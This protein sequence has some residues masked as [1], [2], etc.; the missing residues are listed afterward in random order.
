VV[1]SPAPKVARDSRPEFQH[2]SADSL[3]SD[4]KTALRQQILDITV[5]Q[6]E[7][8]VE[9]DRVPDDDWRKAVAGV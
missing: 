9:P 4:L 3:V 7:A 5:A 1:W 2:P 6:G 8:Q